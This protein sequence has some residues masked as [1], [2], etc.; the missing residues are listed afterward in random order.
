MRTLVG[1]A[2]ILVVLAASA[3]AA[4]TR[5]PAL[6]MSAI[7]VESVARGLNHPW[8]LQFLPD[9]RLIVTERSGS[10]RIV[11]RSGQ[12]SEPLAGVPKVDA[13]GQGG[14]LDIALAPDFAGSSLVYFSY[15]EPRG[16]GKNGTS[17]ARARLALQG[18][19]GRLEDVRV[20][21]RQQP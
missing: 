5:A 21:F 14:L 15:A 18:A 12:L 19:G 7:K 17:V 16:G 10:I 6:P 3:A 2:V 20:I 13:R 11:T 9:G 4:Q 8:G 1:S